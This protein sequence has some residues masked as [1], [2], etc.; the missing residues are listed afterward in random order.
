M[1]HVVFHFTVLNGAVH[2]YCMAVLRAEG[3]KDDSVSKV[4]PVCK[5]YTSAYDTELHSVD[6]INLNHL[7]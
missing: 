3:H 5:A 7:H 6:N 2:T 4:C 1:Q